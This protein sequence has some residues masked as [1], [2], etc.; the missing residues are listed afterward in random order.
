MGNEFGSRRFNRV[1]KSLYYIQGRK[2]KTSKFIDTTCSFSKRKPKKKPMDQ[3]GSSSSSFKLAPASVAAKKKGP[4]RKKFVPQTSKLSD[5]MLIVQE[6]PTSDQVATAAKKKKESEKEKPIQIRYFCFQPPEDALY[7]TTNFAYKLKHTLTDKVSVMLRQSLERY[8]NAPRDSR[9]LGSNKDTNSICSKGQWTPET[10]DLYKTKIVG[11]GTYNDVFQLG[12]V[13]IEQVFGTDV[14]LRCMEPFR[15]KDI[16]LAGFSCVSEIFLHL[17]QTLNALST[18][19]L[20]H[21]NLTLDSLFFDR[22][23]PKRLW[24]GRLHCLEPLEESNRFND[25]EALKHI[26]S[27]WVTAATA[28]PIFPT[29]G[30][31]STATGS[32]QSQWYSWCASVV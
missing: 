31:T 5:G 21:G 24:I 8:E 26:L 13:P 18:R 16:A 27:S 11:K 14:L 22:Q 23:Y 30:T 1:K 12:L 9:F 25:I 20:V 15:Q 32:L 7:H 6:R 3:A 2:L 29:T 28:L 17:M 19:D 4:A 10:L